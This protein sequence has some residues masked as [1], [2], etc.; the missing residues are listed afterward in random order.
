[1]KK[2][3]LTRRSFRTDGKWY[4][5][6]QRVKKVIA[7]MLLRSYVPIR[8]T[9]GKIYTLNLE[10]FA[11]VS[12][13]LGIKFLTPQT[14]TDYLFFSLRLYAHRSLT[15]PFSVLCSERCG[16][17]AITISTTVTGNVRFLDNS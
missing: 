5:S 7:M 9:A 13:F 8:I 2:H 1:M 4:Q 17:K 3:Y 14:L 6:S 15:S 11:A 16:S 10:N 12:E